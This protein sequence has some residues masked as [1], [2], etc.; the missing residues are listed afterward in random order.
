MNG[1][2][3]EFTFWFPQF[4]AY[5]VAFTQA[6]LGYVNS[7]LTESHKTPSVPVGWRA[8]SNRH[9]QV[10]A[11]QL[12]LAVPLSSP[13]PPTAGCR[14]ESTGPQAEVVLFL[15]SR[16]SVV[17]SHRQAWTVTLP[18][19]GMKGFLF[20]CVFFLLFAKDIY[21]HVC[22]CVYIYCLFFRKAFKQSQNQC[23]NILWLL[24]YFQVRT[25]GANSF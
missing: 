8:V 2:V 9:G 11:A 10:T 24:V 25:M 20:S 4:R 3:V 19:G 12:K 18:A 15:K 5:L 1:K 23:I 13:P 6:L 22:V 14:A 21:I 17:T 16:G 7:R